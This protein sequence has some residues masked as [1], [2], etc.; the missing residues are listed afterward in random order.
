MDPAT[1]SPG[2]SLAACFG[3]KRGGSSR[4]AAPKKSTALLLSWVMAYLPGFAACGIF[5]TGSVDV[6]SSVARL[7]GV[8]RGVN[9]VGIPVS[10]LRRQNAVKHQPKFILRVTS[11]HFFS[12][13]AQR[14]K[15]AILAA[16]RF[17]PRRRPSF[18]GK[19]PRR[20]F[21][22]VWAGSVKVPCV[23]GAFARGRGSARGSAIPTPLPVRAMRL[24]VEP[25][26]SAAPKGRA[27]VGQK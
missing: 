12:H 20:A 22:R 15:N 10:P 4:R 16:L 9:R 26:W 21:R 19:A 25:V 13:P 1:Q 17:G 27:G 24:E 18:A 11:T 5:R 23:Q 2:S 3:E 6:L 14:P 8:L 7:P